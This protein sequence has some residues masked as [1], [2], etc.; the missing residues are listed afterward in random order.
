MTPWCC[1]N[2]WVCANHTP[3]VWPASCVHVAA[4]APD[5]HDVSEAVQS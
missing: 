3:H 5:R 4:W 2:P 1:A